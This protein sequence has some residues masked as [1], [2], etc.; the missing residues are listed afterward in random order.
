M[1]TKNPKV[2]DLRRKAFETVARMGFEEIDLM[3]L[4]EI[5]EEII[6][7]E[8]DDI[9]EI[10]ETRTI[11]GE[12][13]RMGLGLPPR[14]PDVPGKLTDGIK[15][16]NLEINE[17]RPPLVNVI[18]MVCKSCPSKK[19]YVTDNCRNCRTKLCAQHCPKGAVKQAEGKMVIDQTKCIHCGLC[20]KHCPYHAITEL[21]R[22]CKVACGADAMGQDEQGRALIDHDKCVACGA[23]IKACP[24]LAISEKSQIYQLIHGLKSPEKHYAIIAPSFTGQFGSNVRPEQILEGCMKLGFEDVVEVGLGAD[25]TTMNEANEYLET[26]PEKAPY[27]GTSC[28]FSWGLMVRYNFPDQAK[29][30]SK[31]F[32]PMIY[33]ADQVKKA[34]PNAKVTFIGPCVSKKVQ[35]L[36]PDVKGHIDYVI[37]F[38]ELRGMFD[39]K[40]VDLAK[41]ET[42][43]KWEDASTTGRNYGAAGGVAEAVAYRIRELGPMRDVQVKSA[44]GLQECMNLVWSAKAGNE[45]GKLLEGMDCKGGCIGG[46][47]TIVPISRSKLAMAKFSKESTYDSPADNKRIPEEDKPTFNAD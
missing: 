1:A 18:R 28:C 9:N 5:V 23:C 4:P 26:V 6:P 33:T 47:G 43:R 31:T 35:A 11:F 13:L 19:I 45:N 16:A 8:G 3:K 10:E 42:D 20:V 25:L 27:M 38:E 46:P 2:V 14:D 30:I 21:V 44:E 12:L 37:T 39:A 29:Y 22:P 24:F 32:S 15:D 7:A 36:E 40:E 41:I 17:Y 34:H